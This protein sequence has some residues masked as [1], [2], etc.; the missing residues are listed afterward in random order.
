[1]RKFVLLSMV[2][3]LLFNCEKSK[4]DTPLMV[5]FQVYKLKGD[6]IDKVCVLMDSEKTRIRA[7][8][9]P[10]S[11]AGD[12]TCVPVKLDEGFYIDRGCIYGLNSVYLTISRKEFIDWVY[13]V[14]VDSYMNYIMDKDPYLEYY[15]A[16]EPAEGDSCS[17]E[18]SFLNKLI[19]EGNQE[20]CFERLK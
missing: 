13:E 19:A 12:T 18:T 6:Y 9:S 5:N 7:T 8:P 3:L 14:P 16:K 15:I 10:M 2:L 4:V 17:V 11:N 1:M 20:Q